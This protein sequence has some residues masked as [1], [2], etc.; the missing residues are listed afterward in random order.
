M[1]NGILFIVVVKRVSAN[2]KHVEEA[3]PFRQLSQRQAK[4]MANAYVC[5]ELPFYLKQFLKGDVLTREIFDNLSWAC[6]FVWI[7]GYLLVYIYLIP[8]QILLSAQRVRRRQLELLSS[9]RSSNSETTSSSQNSKVRNISELKQRLMSSLDLQKN[10]MEYM[11]RELAVENM[12]F[13]M[14]IYTFQE[15]ACTPEGAACAREIVEKHIQENVAYEVNISASLRRTIIQAVEQAVKESTDGSVPPTL[16]MKVE[17]QVYGMMVD[18]FNR[19]MYTS[20]IQHEEKSNS[21]SRKKNPSSSST[22]GPPKESR[23]TKINVQQRAV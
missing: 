16:F 3:Y 13:I 9:K 8:L 17:D 18:P 7:A 1:V 5:F 15:K 19:F 2:L 20:S 21:S 4:F 6:T 11:V 22:A 10:F 14:A 23:R 12:I